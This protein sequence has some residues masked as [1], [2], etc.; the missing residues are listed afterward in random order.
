[1]HWLTFIFGFLCI[2]CMVGFF[3]CLG[4][5]GFTGARDALIILGVGAVMFALASY[6]NQKR[7]ARHSRPTSPPQD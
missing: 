6:L 3:Y 5:G 4:Q 7:H 1:M 2:Y